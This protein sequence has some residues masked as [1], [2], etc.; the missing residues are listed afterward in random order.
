MI[1]FYSLNYFILTFIY[2]KNI[3]I[4]V[5]GLYIVN[6]ILDYTKK[7]LYISL[8]AIYFLLFFKTAWVCDD[9]YINFRSI[10]QLYAGNG[11]VWNPHERVQ[12]YTSP[13]WYWL[14]ASV[15]WIFNDY[16]LCTISISFIL[17][18]F[19]SIKLSRFA[20]TPFN[21]SILILFALASR[22]FYDFASSL[23]GEIWLAAWAGRSREEVAAKIPEFKT[24]DDTDL[25][26]V[27]RNMGM[28]TMFDDDK[29]DFRAMAE[30]AKG[31]I[32]VSGSIIIS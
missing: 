7:V 24:A 10:D 16:F 6:K 11:P 8:I 21:I 3:V 18:C 30:Y 23:S 20:E 17:F 25:A 28:K 26:M 14:H 22:S 4:I 9:A 27:L 19:F 2:L 15:A 13:L 5:F 31:N 12:V 29:A 1:L 32:V